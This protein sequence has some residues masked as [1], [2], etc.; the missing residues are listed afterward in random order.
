MKVRPSYHDCFTASQDMDVL[1]R[2][3]TPFSAF[4]P[5]Q[6]SASPKG[7]VSSN[8]LPLAG[9]AKRIPNAAKI[10]YTGT[11]IDKTERVFGDYIDTYTISQ[12]VEDKATVPIY[13]EARLAKI[14]LPELTV[15]KVRNL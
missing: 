14:D 11:P 4:Q 1:L 7:P 10:G 3:V 9:S 2:G 5:N 15:M 12:S 6:P 8:S 13:Y